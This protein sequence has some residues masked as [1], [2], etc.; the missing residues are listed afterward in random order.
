MMFAMAKGLAIVLTLWTVFGCGGTYSPGQ[1]PPRSQ[2]Q[3]PER[4]CDQAEIQR[5]HP[6][7]SLSS[8]PFSIRPD[9]NAKTITFQINFNGSPD[10]QT[11]DCQGRPV[12]FLWI[13]IWNG[14]Y[15]HSPGD[16]WHIEIS[17]DEIHS[18]G[19]ITIR[20]GNLMP[21]VE[22][23]KVRGQV[24]FRVEG[25]MLEFTVPFDL[26][27]ETDGSFAMSVAILN[28]GSPAPWPPS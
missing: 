26:I 23:G 25:R 14:G 27:N 11:L 6:P 22:R 2:P 13:G 20:N 12:N 17:S 19:Q 24:P 9:F 15:M 21:E 16:P 28:C 18:S 5:T 7:V 10:F 1:Q 4:G 3:P 8:Q